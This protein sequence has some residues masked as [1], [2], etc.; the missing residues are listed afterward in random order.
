MEDVINPN[1]P[2]LLMMI[3]PKN[4]RFNEQT[5]SSNSFQN[6][7]WIDVKAVV[8]NEFDQMV[9]CLRAKQIKVEVVE[10]LDQSLPDAIFP[11]N[12]ISQIPRSEL[13]IYPMLTLNR[14]DEVRNDVVKW[15]S[16]ELA[17]TRTIR[18]ENETNN[19]QFLEGTGSI[20]FDHEAKI[21]YACESPRTDLDLLKRLC[22]DIGYS[23]ISFEA[24]DLK[25]GQIYHTNVMMSIGDQIAIICLESI[26]N[27]IERLMVKN[28]LLNTGK[29]VVE[30][31]YNQMNHFAANAL[32][33]QNIKGKRYF[34]LS[35]TAV[36]SLREDQLDMI[37]S[38]AEI[39]EIPI[40]TI[41]KV[42]GGSVRCMIAGFYLS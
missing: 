16:E 20:V 30:L 33:V 26:P 24:I 17:P 41:E 40:P 39:L 5:S 18:L 22:D 7:V 27:P 32:E 29:I 21:A 38:S 3:R 10:D 23:S 4:F 34:I 14:R 37:S 35:Q 9:S 12:W 2:N 1:I 19:N 25:G 42:G 6:N 8:L 13:I 31:D 15:A 28:S 11:N 36:Q